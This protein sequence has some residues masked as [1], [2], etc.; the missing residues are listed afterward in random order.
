MDLQWRKVRLGLFTLAVLI[1]LYIFYSLFTSSSRIS[2]TKS[3]SEILPDDSLEAD[4][5]TG[6]AKVGELGLG[7]LEM[8]K[9]TTLNPKTKQ[10]E[11]EFGFAKLLHQQ[12]QQWE[13]DKPYMNIYRPDLKC[14][15]TADKGFIVLE[16]GVSPPSPKDATLSGN[17][18]AHI[19][20]E[21]GSD[22]EEC[23][24]YLDDL[25]FVSNKSEFSTE[26]P[27]RFVSASAQVAGRGLRLIYDDSRERLALLRIQ[28]IEDMRFKLARH[29]S[30]TKPDEEFQPSVQ[31]S[32]AKT[33]KPIASY[34]LIIDDNVLIETK[35]EVIAA[36]RININDII[37][38]DRGSKKSSDSKTSSA[39]SVS[40]ED[41]P[42]SRQLMEITV[43]CDNGIV[44]AP[45]D[46]L[47]IIQTVAKVSLEP[48]KG[49][50]V[51]KPLGDNQGRTVFVAEVIDYSAQ[52]TEAVA[53]GLSN[54]KFYVKDMIEGDSSPTPVPVTLTSKTK[55]VFSPKNNKIVFEG[56][57][58]CVM[59]RMQNGIN[60][61]YTLSAPKLIVDL[62]QTKGSKADISYMT[63]IG[64]SASLARL[65]SVRQDNQNLLGGIELKCPRFEYDALKQLFIATGPG[66]VKA[67]NSNIPQ[68]KKRVG[69][70]SLQKPCYALVRNFQKLEYNLNT[71][72]IIAYNDS[73]RVLIDYFPI[74]ETG[75]QQVS[76]A[77]GRI[78]A[79]L[80]QTDSGQRRLW[81]LLATNGISFRDH[82]KLFEASTLFYDDRNSIITARGDESM[83]VYFNGAMFDGLEYDLASEQVKNV[84]ITGPGYIQVP[85]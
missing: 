68:P 5:E 18:V 44:V 55:T 75:R 39:R 14:Y 28:K 60:E 29:Y 20:P 74:D 43:K 45:D 34:K 64:S 10:L 9:F 32:A 16:S 6:V 46:S 65:A 76:V 23:F 13:I 22:V 24:I 63:A 77:A 67:D 17:V 72:Q 47:D 85:R 83:P 3:Q 38:S 69:R 4:S 30:L 37:W 57:C 81:A 19:I 15:V 25:I 49:F 36:G 42:A 80:V 27:I 73:E 61:Q 8:A 56:D 52:T 84:K 1:G 33:E 54:L 78:E 58:F 35:D 2:V 70:F 48:K 62:A 50:D 82:D 79:D 21:P 59:N 51:N 40:T 31:A 12:G 66:V 71:E 26:G 11:R 7:T 53:R 41:R